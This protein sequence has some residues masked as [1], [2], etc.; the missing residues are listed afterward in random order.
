M[1][2][3]IIEGI[4]GLGIGEVDRLILAKLDIQ[5]T[6]ED[7][8][9]DMTQEE[10]QRVENNLKQKYETTF[11]YEEGNEEHL[12]KINEELKRMYGV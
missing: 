1:P 4:H 2:K 5:G 6:I 7:V 11:V 8:K 3:I 10:L 9:L 12:T